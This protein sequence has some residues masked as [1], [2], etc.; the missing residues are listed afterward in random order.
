M[1]KF[2]DLPQNISLTESGK[3][4]MWILLIIAIYSAWRWSYLGLTFNKGGVKYFFFGI[5][6]TILATVASFAAALVIGSVFFGNHPTPSQNSFMT[7]LILSLVLFLGYLAR[8]HFWKKFKLE[9][10][11]ELDDIGN[12]Q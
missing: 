12:N 11:D 8:R 3:T 7:G 10:R 5:V 9:Q 6:T 4:A 2:I 1:D